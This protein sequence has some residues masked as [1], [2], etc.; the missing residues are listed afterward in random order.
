MTCVT[1][2]LLVFSGVR[3]TRS[4][5]LCMFCRSLFVLFHLV[6]M[7]SV[8]RFTASDYP[9]SIFTLLVIVL[10]ILWIT[11]LITPLVSSHFWS[12]CCLSFDLRLLITPLVSSH[13]W[14]LYCLSFDLRLLIIP[15]VSSHVW[16]LCCLSFDLRLLFYCMGIHSID[17]FLLDRSTNIKGGP[18]EMT[19]A[20]ELSLTYDTV[21]NVCIQTVSSQKLLCILKPII[22][23]T[24]MS[25]G[26]CS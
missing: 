18:F 1:S 24:P 2:S 26:R 17:G 8:L 19:A 9:F 22:G 3:V 14:S 21:W 23:N 16:S 10:S 25:H 5:V 7:L 20:T 15:L 13:F 4:L 11:L 6:I 12:L